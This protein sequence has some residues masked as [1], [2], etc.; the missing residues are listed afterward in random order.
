MNKRQ[1]SN[2]FNKLQNLSKDKVGDNKEFN[3]DLE[4]IN[5]EESKEALP[6]KNSIDMEIP[7]IPEVELPKNEFELLYA[8][9][10]N[11]DSKYV[12]YFDIDFMIEIG[13]ECGDFKRFKEIM[14]EIKISR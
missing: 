2:T 10:V 3:F 12:N 6:R 11:K 9:L 8:W 1:S 13:R 4:E 5:E 7:D 14:K